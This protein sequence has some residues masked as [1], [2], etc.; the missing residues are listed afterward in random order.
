MK[1]GCWPSE[2]G[3]ARRSVGAGGALL[4]VA[5]AAVGGGARAQP[6][7]PDGGAD[8]SAPARFEAA[9]DLRGQDDAQAA[10]QLVALADQDPAGEYAAEA[11]AGA[12]E[13]FEERLGRPD[14]ARELYARL[15]AAYPD[16]RLALRAR[17]RLG[18]LDDNLRTGAAPLSEYQRILGGFAGR[19]P[20]ESRR[21][22]GA[23]LGAHPDFALADRGLLWLGTLAAR[24][25]E[26]A[27]AEDRFLEVERRF[28]GSEAAALAHKGRADARLAAG[29]P[30]QARALYRELL[31]GDAARPRFAVAEE[32]ARLG[33]EACRRAVRRLLLFAAALAYL[34]AYLVAGL[35]LARPLRPVRLGPELAYYLPIAGLF[36]VAALRETRAI[37]LAVSLI[38]GG[39]AVITFV[40]TRAAARRLERG[41]PPPLGWP[42]FVAATVLAVVAG[43]LAA[44]HQA[45]L[46]DL[47]IE[48][49]RAGPER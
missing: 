30:L 2:R 13:L 42:L 23:L 21:L 39:G 46:T 47:V 18:F 12:A 36:V 17:A 49:V 43:M 34:S 5:M 27:E 31:L 6:A 11:L 24:A 48:T 29:H 8:R 1:S 15:V 22:M 28:P 19:P 16:S 40:A 25:G 41:R 7:V 45:E 32:G 3:G 4:L 14:R 26:S 38:A 33:L 37:A 44:V 20:A 10:A 9:L 35:L